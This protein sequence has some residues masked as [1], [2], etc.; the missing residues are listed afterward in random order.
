MFV[1]PLRHGFQLAADLV[2][3]ERSNILDWT[4]RSW[5]IVGSGGCR[6]SFGISGLI[7]KSTRN[8]RALPAEN[9]DSFNNFSSLDGH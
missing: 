2:L 6:F 4:V 5:R 3:G 8:R 1:Q 9:Q 7:S